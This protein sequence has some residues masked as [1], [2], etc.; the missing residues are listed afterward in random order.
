VKRQTSIFFY[1]LAA[2]VVLQFVWWGFHLIQ[3]SQELADSKDQSQR[4]V[5]MIV[6]EGSVFFVILLFG[7]WKVRN[8]I[9]KDIALSQRQN[10]F[11]LS[12]TH[13]L[14][15]PLASNKLYLQTL[16]KRRELPN[17]KQQEL[18]N[19]AL[20]EN[21]RLE[22]MIE[23]ILTAARLESHNMTV[24]RESMNLS[25]RVTKIVQQ[26]SKERAAVHLAIES[27]VSAKIDPMILEVV[28]LNLL[29]NAIKYSPLQKGKGIEVALEQRN[30]EVLLH[31]KDQGVG[32][33]ETHRKAIFEK[34]FR[35][36]S[37]ETRS[38]KGSGLGLYI[39]A[40][41]LSMHDAAIEC[42]P[43]SPQGSHFKITF[44]NV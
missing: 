13:E 31:V 34:F 14:K 7:L 10:N 5:M 23:N 35:V 2:Y 4:R 15:T 9:Q 8:S 25:E 36:G 20:L 28:V 41:L 40:Q 6:G 21:K 42:L 22:G 27:E 43:N 33:P 24:N 26:W 30:Q 44:R 19:S 3:L 37:E 11:L 29:E 39:V 38:Q 32:V 18:L 12:V 1:V 17:E 16:L